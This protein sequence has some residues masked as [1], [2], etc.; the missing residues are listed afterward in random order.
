VEVEP[1]RLHRTHTDYGPADNTL[2]F[3][4]DG[5]ATKVIFDSDYEMPGKM[6]G[7]IKDFMSRG[8]IER[9]MHR[10]FEDFKAIAEANVR[11]KT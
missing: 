3:E 9:N 4:P 2:R 6:P 10:L 8:W 11:A 5:E 1:L 7:F